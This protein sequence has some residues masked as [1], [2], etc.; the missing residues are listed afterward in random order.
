MNR[1]RPTTGGAGW[2][3]SAQFRAI[4]RTAIRAWNAKRDQLPRCGARR[5][6]DGS[7]CRQWPMKNGRCY[8]HG[9]ATP[10][11]DQWHRL[12]A[13]ADD[14]KSG[15]KLKR[16]QRA[17]DERAERITAM[18]PAEREQHKAWQRSHKPGSAAARAAEREK[19]RQGKEA[20]DLLKSAACGPR[21]ANPDAVAF[22]RELAKLRRQSGRA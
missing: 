14:R 18:S 4:G 12:Q 3:Q 11:G 13:T 5:K 2:S 9:G 8:L 19:R 21:T 22:Q 16:Q 10:R 17:V 15:R 6:S 7:P 1:Q 20:A